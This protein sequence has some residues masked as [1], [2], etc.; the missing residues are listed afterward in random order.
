[1]SDQNARQLLE[2]LLKLEGLRNPNAGTGKRQFIRFVVRGDAEMSKMD[3]SRL[4]S[5]PLPVQLRDLG[6]GG[7]G[8]VSQHE[9]E[10]DST[11]RCDFIQH[12]YSVGQIAVI[13]RHCRQVRDG[14][15]LVGLQ[16][17]MDHGLL[18]LLGV[19]IQQLHDCDGPNPLGDTAQ[20]LPPAEVA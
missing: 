13:V 20:F 9:F 8:I 17:C 2:E 6:R 16:F 12:G 5:H 10:V 18:A 14:V 3:R 11:W 19:D 4:A 15:N 1:M 7:I